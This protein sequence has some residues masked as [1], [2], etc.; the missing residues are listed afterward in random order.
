M[1]LSLKHKFQSEKSDGVDTTVVQPS[2]WND[3]HALV[4]ATG[5]LL[6]RKTAGAGAVEE[7]SAADARTL[8]AAVNKAGDTMSGDLGFGSGGGKVTG[9]TTTVGFTN[10]AAATAKMNTTTGDFTASGNVTAYSDERL[11][12][13]IETITDALALVRQ[14]RGVRYARRSDGAPG[15]GVVAQEM[16]KVVPEVVIGNDSG[17]L[18]VAYPNLVGVLIE[19]VKELAARVEELEKA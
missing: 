18:S 13:D 14:M 3:E 9:D 7:L 19:A 15:V 8:I 17:Y 12:T 2:N 4:C 5:V 11:K 6:G 1:T 10:G 16:Q